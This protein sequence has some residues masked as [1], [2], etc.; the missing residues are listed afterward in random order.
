MTDGGREGGRDGGTE[1]RREGGNREARYRFAITLIQTQLQHH[2][3]N[4]LRVINSSTQNSPAARNTFSCLLLGTPTV[5]T[6]SASCLY[7]Q[8]PWFLGLKRGRDTDRQVH[9]ALAGQP[10]PRQE[11]LLVSRIKVRSDILEKPR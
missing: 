7:S 1:R 3:A 6:G 2:H 8:Q 9:H 4:H 10:A 11:Q 5:S